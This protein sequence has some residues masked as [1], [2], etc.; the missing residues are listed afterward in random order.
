MLNFNIFKKIFI[1]ESRKQKIIIV[2]MQ[3]NL[4]EHFLNLTDKIGRFVII[5][6]LTAWSVIDGLQ[7]QGAPLR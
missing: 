2:A 7:P 1:S 3:L 4:A 5:G 6:H